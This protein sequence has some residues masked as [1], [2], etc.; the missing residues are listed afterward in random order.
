[1]KI[2]VAFHKKT[3]F[4]SDTRFLN[5]HVGRKL[6]NQDLGF[7]GDDTG[8][9]ISPLNP[10]FCEL[11]ALYWFWKNNPIPN[12]VG[13]CHYRRYFDSSQPWYRYKKKTTFVPFSEFEKAGVE[14]TLDDIEQMLVGSDI[15]LPRKIK[16]A[17]TIEEDY[18]YHHIPEEWDILM[19]TIERKEPEYYK[20]AKLFFNKENYVHAYNMFVMKGP[21]FSSYMAWL[22]NILFDVDQQLKRPG[23]AYQQR[24]IGFMAERLLNLY[25]KHHSF[26]VQTLPIF[27]FN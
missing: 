4:S 20:T 12:A 24:S 14:T 22:F 10:F 6:S 8:E 9:N 23:Y 21:I 18:I 15:V 11:T 3:I 1:M 17:R 7:T 25:V 26:K 13:L 19:K 16:L 27:H 5:I 2:L